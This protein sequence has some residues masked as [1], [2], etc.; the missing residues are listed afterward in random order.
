MLLET[1]NKD[2]LDCPQIWQGRFP[3]KLQHP[4]FPQ[5]LPECY[6]IYLN[7]RHLLACRQCWF[8]GS[9]LQNLQTQILNWLSCKSWSYW[10][11]LASQDSLKQFHS[12]ELSACQFWFWRREVLN[13][14]H[15][16]HSSRLPRLRRQ[17]SLSSRP[18]VREALVALRQ[19]DFEGRL[20]HQ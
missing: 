17:S 16:R 10:Q 15:Q 19:V 4:S 18:H 8:A 20:H 14:D 13:L 11:Q 7:E 3:L 12:W 2:Q 6:C 9:P 1:L 5:C